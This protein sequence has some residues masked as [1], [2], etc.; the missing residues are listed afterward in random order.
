MWILVSHE[1]QIALPHPLTLGNPG[2]P[3]LSQ[4]RRT[5]LEEQVATIVSAY[6]GHNAV[7]PDQ[8]PEVIATIYAALSRLGQPRQ[9]SEAIRPEPAISIRRSVRPDSITCLEC[10]WAGKMIKRHLS[11]SHEL[12]SEQYRAR[13]GLAPEYPLTAPNYSEQRS[14]FAKGSRLGHR[15]AK[16]A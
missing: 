7:T 15:R 13:W 12:S 5:M 9:A 11:S 3:R 1:R 10:G 4:P 6:V 2:H 16:E 8:V 14:A